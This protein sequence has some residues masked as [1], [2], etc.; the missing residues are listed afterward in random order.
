MRARATPGSDHRSSCRCDVEVYRQ[1]TH[2]L[3]LRLMSQAPHPEIEALDKAIEARG[4]RLSLASGTGERGS[5]RR[6][7]IASSEGNSITIPVDDEYGD[8]SDENPSLL[9]HLVLAECESWEEA[10]GL[11]SWA[12]E[13]GLDAAES[14]VAALFDELGRVV[15]VVRSITGDGVKAL[16]SWDVQMNSGAA[17]ALRERTS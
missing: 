2:F 11:P 15:P 9:L 16:G 3:P 6:I 10:D 8:A 4:L 7:G 14:W 12:A 13:A 1:P 5:R 17:R